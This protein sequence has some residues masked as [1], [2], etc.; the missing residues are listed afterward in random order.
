MKGQSLILAAILFLVAGVILIITYRTTRTEGIVIVGGIMF[1]V[2]GL[3]NI[4]AYMA[5]RPTRKEIEKDIRAGRKP[6]TRSSLSSALTWVSSGA[7]VILGLCLLL[8]TS[9]FVS[10]VPF[11]FAL[12]ITF[13]ALYQFYL[14]AIGCRPL[15]LPSWLFAVPVL[16]LGAAIYVFIQKPGIDEGEHIIMLITGISIVVFGLTM[17]V[18]SILIGSANRRLM[19][20]PEEPSATVPTPGAANGDTK[21]VIE[22]RPLDEHE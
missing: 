19:K 9:T 22:A 18:E 14:L 17:I 6:R 2:S 4:S 3:L 7:A 13:S 20:Q 21:P 11:V 10:L 16:M 12:L 1:I 8:F 15:R 5:D